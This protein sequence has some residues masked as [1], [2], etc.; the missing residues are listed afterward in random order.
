MGEKRRVGIT[1]RRGKVVYITFTYKG[2]Q[3]REST[4]LTPTA[5]NLNWA[6]RK[7]AQVIA[8][9]EK[10]NFDYAEHFPKS[11]ATAEF[12]SKP[13]KE[14]TILAYLA[15]YLENAKKRALSP[16]TL[17][18]YQ[19]CVNALAGF[20]HLQV[21]DLKPAD[22]KRFIEK[23]TVSLK[24]MRN[25]LSLLK[26]ALDLAITDGLINTN[27]CT[28]V[29]PGHYMKANSKVDTRGNHQDV[30]PLSPT[31]E[32]ALLNAATHPQLHTLFAFWLHTGL[33]TSELIELKWQDVS[34]SDKKI[35]IVEARVN[36]CYIKA[37]KT[38]SGRRTIELDSVAL[39]ALQHQKQH[40]F[41]VGSHVFLDP[42]TNKPWGSSDSVRKKAWQPL[43]K[44][45]GVRYRRPYNCRHT[46]A[47]RHIS[48]G[49]NLWWLA[50][51][52]GHKSPE[53]IFRHYGSY[54]A[55]H[56]TRIGKAQ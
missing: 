40:S 3:C 41:L 1:V 16:S 39:A 29:N 30:D 36:G 28:G 17:G 4:G 33:R 9:I 47:C 27:P 56:D 48:K 45:A 26:V 46:F 13:R 2:K 43:L 38:R 34:I 8:E 49:A 18:G 50:D 25:N 10:G 22:I 54:M 7:R 35:A 21:N 20:H 19:K 11:K 44:K 52:M 24:T 31:E 23:S 42:A 32:Q 15:N 51:Q 37:P 12:G 14:R 6:A 55:D 5:A 53:M